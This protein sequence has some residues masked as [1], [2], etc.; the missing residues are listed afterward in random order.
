MDKWILPSKEIA[1]ELSSYCGANCVCCPHEDFPLKNRNMD[2]SLFQ[3]CVDDAVAHGAISLD[4]CLMGDALLDPE[5]EKKLLYCRETYPALKIYCS[6]TAQMAKP[7]FVAKY[8]SRVRQV[9]SLFSL[10]LW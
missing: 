3:K 1:M 2:F 6:S 7:Y 9:K 8:K 4:I 5:I 10:A